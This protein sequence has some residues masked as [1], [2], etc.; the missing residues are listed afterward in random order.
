MPKADS[1]HSLLSI[2]QSV[3]LSQTKPVFRHKAMPTPPL[4]PLLAWQ[5]H[6]LFVPPPPALWVRASKV[7]TPSAQVKGI[8]R[9]CRV[10][11]RR[12]ASGVLSGPSIL[13]HHPYYRSRGCTVSMSFLYPTQ[14]HNTFQ[15]PDT[16]RSDSTRGGWPPHP[17]GSQRR[18]L[19][20]ARLASTPT[21][22]A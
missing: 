7:I 1:T 19:D 11:K 14:S 12:S 20:E 15:M 22:P 9:P 3:P 5:G 13:T 8:D 10:T 17:P 4:G 16:S 21:A 2:V 18:S 6:K